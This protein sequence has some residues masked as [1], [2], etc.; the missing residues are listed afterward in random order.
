MTIDRRQACA[1]G[2]GWAFAGARAQVAG[3][4][5]RVGSLSTSTP[6]DGAFYR[7][8]LEDELRKLGWQPGLDVVFE[9]RYAH[10]VRSQLEEHAV[11]LARAR[12]DLIVVTY[13][14]TALI[15]RSA[16]STIP[17]VLI[18]GTDPVGQGLAV[19]LA[20]PGGNVTGV[21]WTAVGSTL[22]VKP[23]QYLRALRPGLT[24]AA[25]LHLDVRGFIPISAEAKES[26]RSIGVA[27]EPV[28]FSQPADLHAAFATIQKTR[29]EVLLFWPTSVANAWHGEV[30]KRALQAR[31]PSASQHV[32]YAREGG[33][34]GYGPPPGESFR[35]AAGYIDRILRGANPAELPIEQPTRYDLFINRRTAAALGLEVPQSLLLRADEVME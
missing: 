27:L 20:R 25:A 29:A 9:R 23:L 24:R 26:A 35:R 22:F 3:K 16:T 12:V 5:F 8:A 4:V 19:S 33:L 17:I 32:W 2:V 13:D 7:T 11:E 14:S 28:G 30:A 21:A 6:A 31:L 18:D 34:L 10:G 1:L 15:A